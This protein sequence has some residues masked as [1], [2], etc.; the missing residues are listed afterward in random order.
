MIKQF[1]FTHWILSGTATPFSWGEKT[2]IHRCDQIYTYVNVKFVSVLSW[3][4]FLMILYI[5]ISLGDFTQLKDQTVLF[6]TIQFNYDNKVKWFQALLY[7]TYNSIKHQS[8]LYTQ[9]N[10]KAVLL[11]TFQFSISH[12]FAVGLNVKQFYLTHRSDHIRCY[13]SVPE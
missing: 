3:V 2:I 5:Y 10:D 1:Y 9:L 11:L 13:H 12:L 6:L 7:I 8:F 4:I